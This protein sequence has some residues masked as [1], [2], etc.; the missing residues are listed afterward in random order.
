M[1]LP[2]AFELA[3]LVLIPEVDNEKMPRIIVQWRLGAFRSNQKRGRQLN[4]WVTD[5]IVLAQDVNQD[6]LRDRSFIRSK[7]VLRTQGCPH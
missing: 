7:D 1:I 6:Q 2:L 4:L 3:P 5:Q